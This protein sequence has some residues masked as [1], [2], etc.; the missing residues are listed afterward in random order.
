[1]LTGGHERG[2][3]NG[4]G[5][6]TNGAAA[7]SDGGVEAL[8]QTLVER[9]SRPLE[10]AQAMPAEFFTNEALYELELERVFHKEWLCVGRQEEIKEPGSWLTANI[11]GEPVVVVRGDDGTIRALSRVCPHRFMDVLAEEKADRGKCEGFVC[12]YHSWAFDFEGKLSGAPLMSRNSLYEREKDSIHLPSFKVELWKGFIFVNLDKDAEPLAPRLA[13]MDELI[14]QYRLEEWH[15]VDRVDWPESPSNW[16][17][18]MDNSRE[19][20]H[21]QGLHRKTVEFLWPSHMAGA[22]TTESRYWYAQHMHCSP[23]AAI[24]EE[25]GHYLNPLVLPPLDGLSAFDRSQY[26]LAGVYPSMFVAAGPDL[27]FYATWRPTG[28]T[29]HKF[30]LQVC[31]HESNLDRPDLD[32]IVAENH[33]WLVEIQSEDAWALTAVQEMLNSRKGALDGGPLSYLERPIWQFQRYM[34]EKLVG[35]EL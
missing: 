12:P 3:V 17:L 16:K 18:C 30:E 28:P 34:A 27:L 21:S 14:G 31:V 25:D 20:Y 4:N 6:L 10:E 8:L 19:N 23:E 7:Q 24:G 9:A 5:S 26:L 29:S 32:K 33:E 22:D 13:D 2:H 11:A 1:V 35:V 15:L